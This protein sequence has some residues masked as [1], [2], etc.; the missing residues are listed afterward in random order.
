MIDWLIE[1][2]ELDLVIEIDSEERLDFVR[3]SEL[4]EDLVCDPDAELELFVILT[5]TDEELRLDLVID[6]LALLSED[7]VTETLT[8]IELEDSELTED[9]V[10][11]TDTD[12]EEIDSDERLDLV[13]DTLMLSELFVTETDWLEEDSEESELFVTLT[14]CELLELRDDFVCDPLRL[15]ELFVTEIDWLELLSE[16]SE[17]EDFVTLTLSLTELELSELRED[18]VIDTET[19]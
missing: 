6:W 17:L 12:S 9:L 11:L 18:L 19:D 14:L 16:D 10:W 2:L 1:T 8:D 5:D 4:R 3:L 15:D 13:T 7:L